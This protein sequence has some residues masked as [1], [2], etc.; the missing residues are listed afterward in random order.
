MPVK[1][2]LEKVDQLKV[3]QLKA[4]L[5]ADPSVLQV[6][7]TH[8]TVLLHAGGL[9]IVMNTQ[10]DRIVIMMNMLNNLIQH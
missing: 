1:T 9:L 2:Y 6:A 5:A 3:D 4:A 8:S 7:C 10:L